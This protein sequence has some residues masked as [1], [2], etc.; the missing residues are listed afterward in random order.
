MFI[1]LLGDSSSLWPGHLAPSS[2]SRLVCLCHNCHG[3]RAVSFLHIKPSVAPC[4]PEGKSQVPFDWLLG[5]LL[6]WP[7]HY[8]PASPLHPLCLRALAQAASHLKMFSILLLYLVN[9]HVLRNPAQTL[10]LPPTSSGKDHASSALTGLWR[11]GSWDRAF[12]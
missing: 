3:E 5:R 9:C 7:P 11:P 8:S 1:Y 4:Y 10:C 12:P 2:P 6:I